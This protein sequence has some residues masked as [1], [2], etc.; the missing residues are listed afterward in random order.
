MATGTGTTGG[1][2]QGYRVEVEQLRAFAAQ[3]RGLLAEFQHH[4]DGTTAHGQSAV[5]KSAL[6]TFAEAT[7]LHDRYQTMRDG[8]RDVLNQLQDAVDDAQKKAELT[9]T[10][11]EEQEH[12]TSGKLKLGDDGWSVASPSAT[13]AVAYAQTVAPAQHSGGKSER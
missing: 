12:R 4:A 8:L 3:V 7:E 10:N 5:G 1:G 11:Y 9:A 6:G 2:G 13:S